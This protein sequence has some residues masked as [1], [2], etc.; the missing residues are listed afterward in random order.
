M[1]TGTVFFKD[2]TLRLALVY[3]TASHIETASTSWS[4][5]DCNNNIF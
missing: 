1:A 3:I 2:L 4:S 5:T